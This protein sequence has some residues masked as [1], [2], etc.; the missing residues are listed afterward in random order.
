MTKYGCAS[1]MREY[2]LN[3]STENLVFLSLL[4]WYLPAFI[5]DCCVDQNSHVFVTL[6][7]QIAELEEE[8]GNLQLQLLDSDESKTGQC[9][10]EL[11]LL[12]W[13]IMQP[14]YA[15]HFLFCLVVK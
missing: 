12:I 14:F 5:N 13:M 9:C 4:S 8:K 6:K 11:S 15:V 2:C 10:C 7:N 1:D 3:C